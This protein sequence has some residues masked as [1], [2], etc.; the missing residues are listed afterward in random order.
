MPN[1]RYRLF[2]LLALV[3]TTFTSV[4]AQTQQ[5]D[6][7][8]GNREP[9]RLGVRVIEIIPNGQAEAGGVQTMDLLAKY[10]KFTIVDHSTY[11]KA[12]EFYLRTPKT[13]VKVVFWRGR[14]P[15]TIEVLPG[16]MGMD[17]NEYNPVGY[18]LD[19]VL[20]HAELTAHIP[21]YQR[22]V[23]FKD[24]F[25]KESIDG[26]LRNAKEMID[27]AEAEGS[28]T[29]TQILV[30]RIRAIPDNTPE[31]ELKKQDLLIAEFLRSQAPEYIA[32]LGEKLEEQD[33]FR[34]ARTLF[35]Q[36]LLAEPNNVEIRLNLG[37]V[38]VK[39]GLWTDVEAGADLLLTNPEGLAAHELYLVHQHKA[40]GALSRGDYDTAIAFA[41]KAWA[42]EGD[43]FDLGLIQLAAALKGDV[44]KFNN[45]SRIYQQ[46]R[47][48]NYEAFKFQI[49]SAE[50]LVL[51]VSGQDE[52]AR[53]VVA[54]RAETDRAEGRLKDYWKEYPQGNKAVENWMRL[55]KDLAKN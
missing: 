27:R 53:A 38:N 11:Y 36:Y 2:L 32:Y 51:A 29:G 19:A 20:K 47:P 40:F 12:R 1:R 6:L 52:L 15:Y 31:E 4:F 8:E 37:Y 10:G 24:V 28:L 9:P 43:D 34:P 54:R 16:L 5:P 55:A 48:K 21:E 30:A 18:A 41:E 50:A 39:L 46:K 26:I 45:T 35:K 13:K 42:H 23:E 49:D 14:S 25:E 44:N 7:A 22:Q 17:T 3:L 33:H